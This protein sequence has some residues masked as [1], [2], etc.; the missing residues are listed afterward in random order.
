MPDR[1]SLARRLLHLIGIVS[2]T[3]S[4][5]Y[6]DSLTRR[7]LHLK[8]PFSFS[9][10]KG[11]QI[12]AQATQ[13]SGID[14]SESI[15]GLL[16]VFKFWLWSNI[17]GHGNHVFKK[18]AEFDGVCIYSRLQRSIRTYNILYVFASW[19]KISPFRVFLKERRRIWLVTTFPHQLKRMWKYE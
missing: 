15:P 9:T 2:E 13:A 14:S 5:P 17:P 19:A 3:P 7:L 16:N 12:W 1:D 11:L 10:V 18:M 8:E 4:V 6:G